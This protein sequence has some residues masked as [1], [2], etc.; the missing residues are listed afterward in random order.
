MPIKAF[1]L[2]LMFCFDPGGIFGMNDEGNIIGRIKYYDVFFIFMYLSYIFSVKKIK[3]FEKELNYLISLLLPCVI[4]YI[5]F[6]GIIIPQLNGYYNFIYF[7]Q[8]NRIFLYSLPIFAMTIY[9]AKLNIAYF[10]KNIIWFSLIFLT[11]YLFSL[12]TGIDII[13][14]VTISRFGENDR[15]FML[16]YSLFHLILPMGIV[17]FSILVKYKI[18]VPYKKY[19][20]VSMALMLITYVLTLTRREYFRIGFMAIVIPLFVS[21]LTKRPIFK[22][23]RR[24]ILIILPVVFMVLL[25]FPE[26]IINVKILISDIY[27]IITTG[28]D[29]SGN[30]DSR[31]AGNEDYLIV[32][33][34]INENFL[35]GIGYY[36]A[37]WGAVVQMKLSGNELG[38]AL[39]AS[40]EVP[41]YGALMRLG[42]IGLIIPTIFYF[43]LIFLMVRISKFIRSNFSQI[44][45][46]Y[47]EIFILITLLFILIIK[48]TIE[49]YNLFGEFYLPEAFCYNL[50]LLAI[51]VAIY[52]KLKLTISQQ[53][54][55]NIK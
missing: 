27:S 15:V 29:A 28:A 17:I 46:H 38:L 5:V 43:Y 21:Y 22:S 12:I 44:I 18:N 13:K 52:Q 37:N 4:Y 34:I 33:R 20:I 39:D 45:S 47:I 50:V 7:I 48:F 6:S 11:G 51:T 36:P 26:Y 41:I 3:I 40:S 35:W 32:K 19:I 16:S 24:I 1:W 10:Y 42:V 2:S 9:F 55:G 30:I 53:K 54:L 25:I 14:H 23:I 49:F 31:I 8:K